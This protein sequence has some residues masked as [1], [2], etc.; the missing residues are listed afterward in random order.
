MIFPQ[1]ENHPLNPARNL[2]K[3]FDLGIEE[4]YPGHGKPFKVENAVEEF[5]RWRKRILFLKKAGYFF[6]PAFKNYFE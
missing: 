6:L 4:I 2:A 5:E 3:L 1:I